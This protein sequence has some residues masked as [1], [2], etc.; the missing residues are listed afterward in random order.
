MLLES[1]DGYLKQR[2][3]IDPSR[4]SHVHRARE[5][6]TKLDQKSRLRARG[7]G[8]FRGGQG[9]RLSVGGT[10]AAG[11]SSHNWPKSA[12]AG[13]VPVRSATDHGR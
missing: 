7:R 13:F 1:I 12:S 4:R 3:D 8:R 6:I 10:L 2:K 11:M 9:G 5:D